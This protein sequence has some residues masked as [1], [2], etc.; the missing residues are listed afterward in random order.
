[1]TRPAHQPADT[2][3]I[4]A[5][6]STGRVCRAVVARR[7]NGH[8][9]LLDSREFTPADQAHLS[10]WLDQNQVGRVISVL[11]SSRVIC[12]TA[13]LPDAPAEQL[14]AALQLQAETYLLGTAPPHRQ[15]MA[16][17]HAA[18]GEST[19]T[20][21]II[22]WPERAGPPAI[23][24]G[25]EVTYSADVACLA[26]VMNGARSDEPLMWV[27]RS[28]GSV[29][30]ALCHTGGTVF[31]ASCEKADGKDAW[32]AAIGRMVAETAYNVGHTD[33]FTEMLVE[34]TSD[35][36]A[37]TP[38]ETGV[39]HLP[40]ETTESAGSR[41][42]GAGDA[43]WW[44]KFGIAAGA[45]LATLDQLEPLTRLRD[46]QPVET[47][48][49]VDR[50]TNRLGTRTAA[51]R[52]LVVAL[53]VIAFAPL[54]F[55]AARMAVLR[56]K[57]GDAAALTREL[58]ASD[59][60]AAIYEQLAQTTFP[61]AKLLADVVNCAPVGVS[62]DQLSIDE[63]GNE[64]DVR[65]EADRDD[66]VLDFRNR[67]VETAV[68]AD[69]TIDY[70]R[71]DQNSPR[72]KMVLTG[73]VKDPYRRVDFADDFA[74]DPL[75]RRIHGERFVWH[76]QAVAETPMEAPTDDGGA[77]AGTNDGGEASDDGG[78]G[79]A[80]RDPFQGRTGPRTRPA[81]NIPD[82]AQ[83]GSEPKP[84]E[85]P[86]PLTME[87]IAALKKPQLIAA[88]GKISNSKRLPGLTDEQRRILDEQFEMMR[89]Q[90]PRAEE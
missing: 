10:T 39:L 6:H 41:L 21:L 52:W 59:R 54:A 69:V 35:R 77:N 1:M 70:N 33:D 46:S 22:A 17:L 45:L 83:G 80:G 63:D 24:V 88:L 85:I 65:G 72:F 55:A 57:V 50:V 7:T 12:R 32:T 62:I 75:G 86:T 16:V 71:R 76:R 48:T 51:T 66:L 37:D 84:P 8:L 5:V 56:L 34:T 2:K 90:L 18:P 67:L 15:S 29:A 60:R 11:P 73:K 3:V 74:L 14:S 25:R 82:I 27:D 38:A 31:R 4:A 20:G 36:L 64:F 13:T 23:D 47:P 89:Q 81:P 79:G 26:A 28:D 44:A 40:R 49:L 87:E 61:M 58:D 78:T 43:R 68:F 53:V 30:L 42:R 19:R 9:E